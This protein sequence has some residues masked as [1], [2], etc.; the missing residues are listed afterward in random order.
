MSRFFIL[1][2]IMMMLLIDIQESSGQLSGYNLLNFQVGNLPDEEPH[3]LTSHFNQLNLTYRYE[4]LK[5]YLRMEHFLN[6]FEDRRYHQLSQ[7]RVE[8]SNKGIELKV[9]HF[10][11]ML[12][13]GLLLRAYE[14]PGTIYEEAGFRSQY[15]F[16]RDIEGI[17]AGYTGNIFSVKGIR[18][19]PLVNEFPPTSPKEDRRRD[20]IE[21]IETGVNLGGQSVGLVYLRNNREDEVNNFGS[22][23]LSGSLPLSL[24]YQAEFSREIGKDIDF[25]SFEDEARFAYYLSLNFFVWKLGGSLEL[26]KYNNYFLGTGFN[27]PPTLVKEQAYKVLNRSTH[28]T[29]LYTEHG[30]QVEMYYSTGSGQVITFNTSR[31]VNEYSTDYV[32]SEYFLELFSPIGKKTSLKTFLDYSRDDITAE[33]NRYAGGINLERSFRGQWGGIARIEYQLIERNAIQNDQIHNGVMIIGISKSAKVTASV[34]WET[35]TDPYL[36][37]DFQ[38]MEIETGIRHWLGANFS[39]KY[40]ANHTLALFAGSRRGGPACTSGICY[41]VLDFTGVELRLTSKF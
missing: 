23:A 24:S 27:D 29:D 1:I 22:L 16:Y 9:G 39:Y 21:A 10:Y 28:V 6:R 33:D 14:I 19:M 18:G 38:T 25:F 35:S 36:T 20:L 11:D 37:D 8:Y 34:V 12:G 7:Y 3:D 40:N 13:N 5:A 2:F 26:K 15:G 17:S 30:Y 4:S 32:F 41:E 31:A